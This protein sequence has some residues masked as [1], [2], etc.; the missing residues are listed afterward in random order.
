MLSQKAPSSYNAPSSY[1]VATVDWQDGALVLLDQRKLPTEEIYLSLKTYED[2]A[3]AIS[4]MTVRGAPA[5]GVTAAFGLALAAKQSSSKTFSEF[6]K[7]IE[8]ASETLFKTRPTAVNLAW[9]LNR[10]KV[11]IHDHQNLSIPELKKRILAEAIKIK[12]EDIA[13]NKKIG[14]NG[15]T[16]LRNGDTILTHCNAGALCAAGYGT[17]LGVI[18]AAK[19]IGK[20]IKVFSCETRPFLQGARLT[21]WELIQN[22]VPTTMI[23]DNMAG[24]FM[25]NGQ[26]QKVIVGADRIAANGDTANKIGTYSLAILARHHDIPF[27]VAAPFSS[28]DLMLE[29]GKNIPI[30]ERPEKE[31]TEIYGNRIAAQGVSVKNPAFD[32]TPNILITEI[33]TE[34]GIAKPP[35]EES[36]AKLAVKN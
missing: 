6:H 14:Q 32:V 10:V 31:V 27:Y 21:T 20:D 25:K 16:L 4:N 3:Q 15:Q 23:T 26:I 2:V 12:D 5:I 17:A 19:E 28:I 33:I 24:H 1:M 34:N 29:N 36:L 7:D 8:R 11:L 22:K 9:A 30:E 13:C 35:F 18:Y